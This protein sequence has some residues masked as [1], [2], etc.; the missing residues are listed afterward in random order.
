[1]EIQVGIINYGG[2]N[3]RSI[4]NA[5]NFLGVKHRFIESPDEA[6]DTTHLIFP[7][8]GAFGDSLSNIRKKGLDS[9]ILDWTNADKPFFGICVGF[10]A[11]FEES[12]ESEGVEGLGVFKGQVQHFNEP[13]L[14]TPHMGWN[15][16]TI[17]KSKDAQKFW[18]TQSC[19]DPYFYFIHS[20]HP[21]NV[22][23][24]Y[25]VTNTHYGHNFV[26][27]IQRGQLL[28]TQFHPEKSQDSGI[29]LIKQFLTVTQ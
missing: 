4:A 22:E 26:S 23:S 11:L 8:Q 5:F 17:E 29:A 16:A 12:S 7:G 15:S 6:D 25:A 10:Q 13:D 2:G 28:A 24:E 9:L 20:F 3:L 18:E 27:A 14:K 1:M 19:P 21:V